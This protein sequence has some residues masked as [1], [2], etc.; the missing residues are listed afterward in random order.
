MRSQSLGAERAIAPAGV[1]ARAADWLDLSKPRITG[2]V[3]VS[4][5]VG[6]LV[7]AAGGARPAIVLAAVAG[8]ALVTAGAQTINQLLERRTD[9]LMLRTRSRPLPAGRVGVPEAA[10]LGTVESVAGLAILAAGTNL[11]TAGLGLLAFVL[12]TAVYTPLKQVS[13]VCTLV[14]A[15]PGA[16]PP[17]MG[18]TAATGRL[19]AGAAALFAILFVWQLPHFYAIAWMYRDDYAR[20]RL[21]IISVGDDSGGRTTSRAV[22]WALAMIPA[23]LAPWGAGLAGPGYA[24][25]ATGLCSLYLAAAVALRLRRELPEARRLLL[26]SVATLPLLLLLLVVCAEGGPPVQAAAPAASALPA[27]ALPAFSLT[28]RSGRTVTA[29]SLRG[30]VWV[31]GFVFTRCAGVCPAMTAAMAR[32]QND[33]ADVPEFRLVSISVDPEYDTPEV[34]TGYAAAAGADP[35]R[36][37]F[38]TGPPAEITGLSTKGFLLAA[39]AEGD[40]PVHSQRLALVDRDGAVRGTWD[41][42]D[43]QA[44]KALEAQARALAAGAAPAGA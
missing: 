36:W 35:E 1:L 5:F 30:R 21:A 19:D 32:L 40:N 8:T 26:A 31:A 44:L 10:I 28:E 14:G 4:A 27:R 42:A 2:M 39:A 43:P 24:A 15:V 17:V 12:Y 23:S 29:E 20:A 6:C 33:L 38:L 18:Y 34:L 7:G 16:M 37:L 3:L 41:S 25:G 9:A 13:P 22:F 11:L